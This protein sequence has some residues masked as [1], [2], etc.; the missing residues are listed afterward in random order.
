AL[1]GVQPEGV[2]QQRV[3]PRLLPRASLQVERHFASWA[4]PHERH[5]TARVDLHG[6]ASSVHAPQE[7]QQFCCH[8]SS[9]WIVSMVISTAG[10]SPRR[11]LSCDAV[12]SSTCAGPSS[13]RKPAATIAS[14]SSLAFPRRRLS[15][16]KSRCLGPSTRVT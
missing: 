6:A 16:S 5:F 11:D 12:T 14:I 7:S 1:Y 10:P 4:E 9:S 2:S 13:G 3:V 8:F 15:A